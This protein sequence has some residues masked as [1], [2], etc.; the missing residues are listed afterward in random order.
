MKIAYVI[1][2]FSIKGGAERILSRKANL[3]DSTYGHEVTIIS[4]YHDERPQSYPLNK[5]VRLVSLDVDF[6]DNGG[7]VLR[8]TLNRTKTLLTALRRFNKVVSEIQPDVIFFTMIIGALLLPLCRT[9]AR[10]VYESH[11]ARPFTPYQRLFTLMERRADVVVCLTRDDARNYTKARETVVIPN[12]IDY[13]TPPAVKDYSVKKAIAVGR[14]ESQK[15]FDILINCWKEAAA[16]HPG[17]TLDIYGEGSLRQQLQRQ[18]DSCGLQGSVRLQGRCDDMTAAYASNSLHLM[19]SR[20]EGQPMTLIEAQACGLPSVV[21]DFNYGAKDIIND[22]YNGLIVPQGDTAAYARALSRMM[23]DEAL[24][25]SCGAN[26]RLT[27]KRFAPAEIM[28]KWQQLV[29]RLCARR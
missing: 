28:E 29:N 25:A 20:Y 4:I 7:N 9:K 26:A 16:A 22:G 2:D 10:R 15:G 24:R 8:K 5:N 13:E 11:V 1:E 23:A 19:T 12:F 14:L 3:L 21:T 6:T 17:W 27:A 18:I